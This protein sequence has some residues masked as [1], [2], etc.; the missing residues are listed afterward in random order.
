[1]TDVDV[2]IYPDKQA[3]A[4][5]VSL[6][7]AACLR[8]A[9]RTRG[10]AHVVL[11]GGSMGAATLEGLLDPD[12]ES[13]D[14]SLVH[15]W[16][17]DDRFVPSGDEER[18]ETQARTALLDRVGIDPRQVHA[19]APS[20][21]IDG[22]DVVAAAARYAEELASFAPPGQDSPA[23]DVLLL[24]VGPDAHVASL[25]P[26]HPAQTV[27]DVPAVAVQDSPKPPPTRISLTFP[28]LN[29][30]RRVWF[31]VAGADKAD[32]ARD[33]L[34]GTGDRWDTPASGAHGTEETVWW[35]DEAAAAHLH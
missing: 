4:T 7:L 15:V 27:V 25:F 12:H 30:A 35:L 3:T 11:T 32:A 28:A 26:H 14:W 20:D 13:L 18:N 6:E 2:R 21:G 8:E 24:G 22:D 19:M 33:A 29:G 9:I 5:A 34:S 1:M 16:W 23:F 31:V 17:G 10:V